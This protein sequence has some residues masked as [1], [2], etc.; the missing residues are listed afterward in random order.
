MAVLF[1][2]A[3]AIGLITFVGKVTALG[4]TT[5]L[6]LL[7]VFTVVNICCLILRRDP[8]EHKHFRAPTALPILGALFCAYLVGPWTGRDTN[9]YT[10][11]GILLGI[12]VALWLLTFLIN[13][14]IYGRRTFMAHPEALEGSETKE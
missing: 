9:Q 10:I 8:K 7:A 5:A 12:G 2:S 13:R 6:L 1:T 3:L 4:G 11:A 14:A